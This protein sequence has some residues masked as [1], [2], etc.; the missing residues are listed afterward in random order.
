MLE[1]PLD[2]ADQ[3]LTSLNEAFGHCISELP[4]PAE[5][6]GMPQDLRDGQR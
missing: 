5:H 1:V 4:V 6:R 2:S 3:A